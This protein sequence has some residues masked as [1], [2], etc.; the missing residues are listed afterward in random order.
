M[1][2]T[3]EQ[4]IARGLALAEKCAEQGGGLTADDWRGVLVAGA[5]IERY[6]NGKPRTP[7]EQWLCDA[8]RRVSLWLG[9]A[10][11]EDQN[12]EAQ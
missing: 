7:R 9:P 12:A 4:I 1:S 8:S 6:G 10:P 5:V 3:E 2:T 11:E